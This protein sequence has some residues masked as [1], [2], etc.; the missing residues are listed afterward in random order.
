[1]AITAIGRGLIFRRTSR[2]RLSCAKA[3]PSKRAFACKNNILRR[4]L[5]RE[6]VRGLIAEQLKDLP[7]SADNRIAEELGAESIRRGTGSTGRCE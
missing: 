2:R 7:E 6:Q 3:S 1:M 4:H 5:T